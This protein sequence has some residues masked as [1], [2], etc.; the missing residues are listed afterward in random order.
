MNNL[1]FLSDTLYQVTIRVWHR[2]RLLVLKQNSK[3]NE[4]LRDVRFKV[5]Q[6]MGYIKI[7]KDN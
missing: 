1:S 6:L 2:F 4:V 3:D 5:V 7:G